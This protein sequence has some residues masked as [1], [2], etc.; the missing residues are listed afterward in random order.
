MGDEIVLFLDELEIRASSSSSYAIPYCRIC[1]EAEFESSK[2]FESPCACSGTI[3]YAHRDCIQR[4]C[5]EKGNTL[6]EICL[7]KFE[8][9]YTA[10][11]KTSNGLLATTTIVMSIRDSLEVPRRRE[12]E[13]NENGR[14]FRV[15][16][17]ENGTHQQIMIRNNNNNYAHFSS[18]SST[19]SSGGGRGAKFWRFV[20]LLM[21][22][23]L[24]SKHTFEVIMGRAE[25]YP[26]SLA[27]VMGLF[28]NLLIN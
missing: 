11:P 14:A 2:T 25:D 27:A 16:I 12:G 3:Q 24:L 8:P 15:I 28:I 5:D 22:M 20:A 7:Q 21:T 17:D 10:A 23:V 6:C 19:S 18:S 1:H 13:I 26:F 4:W 9:G